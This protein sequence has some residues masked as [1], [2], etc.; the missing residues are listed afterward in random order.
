M[1]EKFNTVPCSIFIAKA[2]KV[3]DKQKFL[4]ESLGMLHSGWNSITYYICMI[5]LE[6]KALC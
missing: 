1:L 6:H 3:Q 5:P 4:W 2:L